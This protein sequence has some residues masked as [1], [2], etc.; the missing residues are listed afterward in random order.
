MK[1][2]NTASFSKEDSLA[3]KGIAI[4]MLMFYHCFVT[5]KNITQYEV[6]IFPLTFVFANKLV[7]YFKICV[8][9]FA[10]ISGYGLL[11]SYQKSQD[12]R[13]TKWQITRIVKT[14]SGFWFLLAA[15]LFAMQLHSG[16][17]GRAYFRKGIVKGF[18]YLVLEFL[19]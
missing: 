10:F 1:K 2:N 17:I 6:N 15:L 14:L 12:S 19:L 8:P 5:G 18:V 16:Y 11:Q 3:L 7:S 13:P 9:I 4:L